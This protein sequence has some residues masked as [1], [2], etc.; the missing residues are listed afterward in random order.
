MPSLRF[1][2]LC[3]HTGMN[4]PERASRPFDKDRDGFV[5]S[6][7]AGIVVLETLDSCIEPRSVHIFGELIGYAANCD[8]YNM[9]HPE[10]DG[11]GAADCMAQAISDAGIAPWEVDYL[12]AHG[13]STIVGD[14]AEMRAVRR[15]FGEKPPLDIVNQIDG[16][17]RYWRCGRT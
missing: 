17:P 7:G 8:A 15:V 11:L 16:R 3:L 1:E 10:P 9:T 2:S 4:V 5:I 6:G 13:T 14:I 12:N